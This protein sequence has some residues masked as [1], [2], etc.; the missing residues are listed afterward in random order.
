MWVVQNRVGPTMGVFAVNER[1]LWDSC[2]NSVNSVLSSW[3]N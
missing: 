2:Y 1:R 3:V